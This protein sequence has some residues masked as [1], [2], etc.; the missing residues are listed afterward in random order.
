M[1]KVKWGMIFLVAVALFALVVVQAQPNREL[2]PKEVKQKAGTIQ[3]K[4]KIEPVIIS[5]RS[6]L[7]DSRQGYKMVTD[8]VDAFG[9]ES[10]STNYKTPVNSGG[11][12]TAGGISQSNNYKVTAGYVHASFVMRGDA[13]ADGVVSSADVVYLINYLFISGPK[14]CPLEAGDATCDG[15]IN[16]ADIVFLINYLFVGGP[17]PYNL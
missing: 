17:P 9:G 1:R 12:P 5:E 16:S 13:S 15:I 7:G 4:D 6:V 8:V 10:Q 11:Q 2:L 3:S 14:P